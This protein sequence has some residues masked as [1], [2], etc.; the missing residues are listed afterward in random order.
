VPDA[1]PILAPAL[2]SLNPLF[3]TVNKRGKKG[4][5]GSGALRAGASSIMLKNVCPPY[6]LTTLRLHEPEWTN[7][8]NKRE[9]KRKEKSWTTYVFALSAVGTA[10]YCG[11]FERR[12]L[13]CYKG[14]TSAR[15]WRRRRKKRKRRKKKSGDRPEYYL[16]L[17]HAANNSISARTRTKKKEGRPD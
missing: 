7:S 4:G 8:G 1:D 3:R 11:A 16:K 6:L 5:E 12:A 2:N 10:L 14:A 17:P 9:R 13:Y 15:G